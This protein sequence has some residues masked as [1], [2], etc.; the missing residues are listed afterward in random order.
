[1]K[2]FL[3]NVAAN[4]KFVTE[5]KLLAVSN[6]TRLQRFAF[7]RKISGPDKP[8]KFFQAPEFIKK[9]NHQTNF[10]MAKRFLFAGCQAIVCLEN[11]SQAPKKTIFELNILSTA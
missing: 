9:I 4:K 1:M 6:A 3:S 11:R 2:L 5:R 10:R 8:T 7:P